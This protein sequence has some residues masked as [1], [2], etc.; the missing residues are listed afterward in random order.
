MSPASIK[1]TY[2]DIEGVAESVRLALVLAGINFEDARIGREEWQTLKPT[3]PYGQLPLLEVDGQAPKA[4]S[5]AMLR[6]IGATYSK[7]LYPREQ[8][9]DIEEAMG[10]VDDWMRSF[11]PCFYMGTRP[12]S[13]GHP[14]GFAQTEE[15]KAV[16]K[17]IREKWLAEELPKRI[18]FL[19]SLLDRHDGQWL[20]SSSSPTIA[21]CLAV[22][23]LRSLTRGYIDHVPADCLAA[24]P[25]IVDYIRRFCA[26]EGVKGRYDA[27]VY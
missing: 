19:E 15:G 17:T 9:Y 21:D 2:F 23:V 26:L 27:G 13:F 22:P 14:P 4:Q 3:T 5:S 24:H 18:G 10:V 1:L 16:V 20:A 8:L 25:R 12:E 7:T 11:L 6:W